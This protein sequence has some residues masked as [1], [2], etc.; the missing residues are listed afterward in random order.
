MDGLPV[1]KIQHLEQCVLHTE[2]TRV[3]SCP[4]R[5]FSCYHRYTEVYLK[6]NLRRNFLMNFF[7]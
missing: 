3:Y 1:V 6:K 5:Y 2:Y 7:Q 4:H